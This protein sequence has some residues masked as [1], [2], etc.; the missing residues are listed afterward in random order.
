[1]FKAKPLV[2]FTVPTLRGFGHLSM[3]GNVL[4]KENVH[5]TP[6]PFIRGRRKHTRREEMDTRKKTLMNSLNNTVF[7]RE[8]L[9]LPV[10]CFSL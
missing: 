2:R 8:E 4:H 1:M 3:P 5:E 10:F 7:Q 6:L 9:N